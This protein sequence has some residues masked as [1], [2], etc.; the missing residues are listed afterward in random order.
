MA[1]ERSGHTILVVEDTVEFAQLTLMTL[2][3]FGFVATH[4]ENYDDAVAY[5]AD[6]TPGLILL[7]LNLNGS[8]GWQIIETMKKEYGK[9]VP[10]VVTTA[11]SD[12]AN[13]VV[14]KLQ[15]VYSYLV[16]PFTPQDLL[17]ACDGALGIQA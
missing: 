15:D 7:D 6:H 10:V 14:G 16:K 8:S 5:L 17:D 9:S 13:R 12:S 2:K 1:T 11:Y 3:R 4:V